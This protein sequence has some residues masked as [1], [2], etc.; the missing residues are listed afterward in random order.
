MTPNAIDS[1]SS[2]TVPSMAHDRH[3]GSRTIRSPMLS[4]S[5]ITWFGRS[6]RSH[7]AAPPAV[8]TY[9]ARTCPR[10]R[11]VFPRQASAGTVC[12]RVANPS[13]LTRATR[14]VRFARYAPPIVLKPG[15]RY[16]QATSGSPDAVAAGA[17]GRVLPTWRPGPSGSTSRRSAAASSAASRAGR[18]RATPWTAKRSQSS[19]AAAS[20]G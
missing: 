1:A 17:A 14:C 15:P 12:I 10:R 5:P 18:T 16:R 11:T 7:S 3:S 19:A 6:T 4:K 13:A 8:P 9:G 2:A 20:L